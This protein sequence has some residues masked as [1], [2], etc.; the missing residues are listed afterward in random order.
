VLVNQPDHL[1]RVAHRVRRKLGAD[2]LVDRLA[3]DVAQVEQAPGQR[4]RS[5]QRVRLPGERQRHHLDRVAMLAQG[6]AQALDQQLGAAAHERHL[7]GAD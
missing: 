2:H 5:D 3:V 4:R 1:V 6:I 7:G